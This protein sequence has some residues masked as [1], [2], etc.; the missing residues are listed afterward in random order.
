MNHEHAQAIAQR[1]VNTWRSTPRLDEWI[2]ELQHRDE[3]RARTA[4]GALKAKRADSL[5]IPEF[6]KAYNAAGRS[7]IDEQ[8]ARCEECEGTGCVPTEFTEHGHTYSAVIAC[9]CTAGR[10]RAPQLAELAKPSHYW[11]T[12][13][14]RTP[15]LEEF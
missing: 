2:T 5:T 11:P 1:I 13:G 8:P 12:S 4:L 10:A 15:T 3:Q 7:H 14:P 6:A 9:R